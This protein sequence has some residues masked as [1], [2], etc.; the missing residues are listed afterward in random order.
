MSFDDDHEPIPPLPW[1]E[2]S[3]RIQLLQNASA[4][5]AEYVRAIQAALDVLG[6][7]L[8]VVRPHRARRM[9]RATFRRR[10]GSVA[11]RC[12][13]VEGSPF[14]LDLQTGR[15]FDLVKGAQYLE[16]NGA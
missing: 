8:R 6:Y 2:V 9:V 1:A 12:P 10:D 14:V 7:E 15:Y 4:S 5:K 13:V 3:R 11:R 16:R